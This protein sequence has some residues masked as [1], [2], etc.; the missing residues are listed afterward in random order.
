[1]LQE[2]KGDIYALQHLSLYTQGSCFFACKLP[3][4]STDIGYQQT[5]EERCQTLMGGKEDKETEIKT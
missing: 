4:N 2:K 5:V 1:M 3:S